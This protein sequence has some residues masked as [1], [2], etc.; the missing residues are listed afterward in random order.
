[1]KEQISINENENQYL[2]EFIGKIINFN[3]KINESLKL[4]DD[5]LFFDGLLKKE[6]FL[7]MNKKTE[8]EIKSLKN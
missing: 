6:I 4:I 2:K 8:E 1:M 5:R 7:N 3:N